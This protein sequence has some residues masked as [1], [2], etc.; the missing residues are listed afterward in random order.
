MPANRRHTRGFKARG[1]TAHDQNGAP[2]LR[3]VIVIADTGLVPSLL[4]TPI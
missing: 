3:T 1:A 4:A 2:L